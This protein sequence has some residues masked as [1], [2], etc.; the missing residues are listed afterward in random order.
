MNETIAVKAPAIINENPKAAVE[1]VQKETEITN[2]VKPKLTRCKE[3]ELHVADRHKIRSDLEGTVHL[4]S[5]SN[6]MDYVSFTGCGDTAYSAFR[7]PPLSPPIFRPLRFN[8]HGLLSGG[9][10]DGGSDKDVF[11]PQPAS[12]SP[13][14]EGEEKSS[15][16]LAQN[17]E[18]TPK[19]EDN[20]T[21]LMKKLADEFEESKNGERSSWLKDFNESLWS[22]YFVSSDQT[23]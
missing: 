12:I 7:S 16:S 19:E 2:L 10:G 11:K 3:L 14:N 8:F 5:R 9:C 17:K 13:A 18:S 21:R 15:S 4:R 22:N 1:A 6:E 20:Q 23:F